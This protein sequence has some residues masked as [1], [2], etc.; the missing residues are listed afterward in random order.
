M[1]KQRSSSFLAN[2]ENGLKGYAT[3]LAGFCRKELSEAEKRPHILT[4]ADQLRA[5]RLVL[6]SETLELFSRYQTT[7]DNQLYKALRAF[8]EAQEWRL[9]TLD[10]AGSQTDMADLG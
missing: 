6:P 10:L 1:K 2:H 5:K 3:D 7:L 9:K 8:R 4:L